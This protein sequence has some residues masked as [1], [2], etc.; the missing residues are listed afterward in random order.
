MNGNGTDEY[1]RRATKELSL[2][3]QEQ[4]LYRYHLDNLYGTGKIRQGR[5]ISTVL[6]TVVTGPD[7]RYYNIPT[8]W[9]GKIL[10]PEAAQ[11]KA[12]E[13]GWDKWPSYETPD[14]ADARYMQMHGYFDRDI[15]VYRNQRQR[16]GMRPQ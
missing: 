11:A 6:Q 16:P 4:N 1:Y 14:A 7:N 2:T 15:G 8:V 12:A 9:G 5:D 10:S 13:I 3:P